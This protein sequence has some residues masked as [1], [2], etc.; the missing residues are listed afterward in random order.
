MA[1][2][3]SPNFFPGYAVVNIPMQHRFDIGLTLRAAINH[4]AEAAIDYFSQPTPP[5]LCRDTQVAPLNASPI[6]IMNR[7]VCRIFGA[8]VD[9]EVSLYGESVPE[10]SWWS[11]PNTT[12][13]WIFP[14]SMA[15]LKA[16]AILSFL[17]HRH[18]IFST[19][20]Q[21]WVYFHRLVQSR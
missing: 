8:I 5:P 11:L 21:Q 6:K 9:I 2:H 16:K 10:T 1:L 13:P 17:L 18:I 7:H 14:S 4:H 20:S 15:L 12:G 3:S 19:L